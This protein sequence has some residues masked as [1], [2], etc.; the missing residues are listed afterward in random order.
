MDCFRFLPRCV[1]T[2]LYRQTETYTMARSQNSFI[3][4]Q[5]AEKK[6]KKQ[7]EK[8][9]KRLDRKNQETDGSLESMLAYTDEFG[10]ILDS[11]PEEETPKDKKPDNQ[12]D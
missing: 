7:K 2:N 11:P 9:E 3:K 4:K 10:N 6:R 8:L 5:K 12:N 1:V